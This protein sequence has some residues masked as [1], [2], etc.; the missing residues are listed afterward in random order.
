MAIAL[1]SIFGS[2]ITV[3]QQPRE[4]LYQFAP[5]PAAHGLVSMWLGTVGRQLVIAGTLRAT[6]GTYAIAR[7]ALRTAIDAI[8]SYQWA[9][10]ADYSFA[11]EVFYSVVFTKF[12]LITESQNKAFHRT[13]A[14]WVTCRFL[15][16]GRSLV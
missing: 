2:E 6:G 7:A 14:G 8:E 10:A 5:F 16:H 15:C 12:T 4:S 1:T 13:S 3:Y 11:G 9:G